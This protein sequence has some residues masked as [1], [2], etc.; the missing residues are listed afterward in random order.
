MP[1]AI[2]WTAKFKRDVK[3]CQKQGKDIQKFKD[4]NEFLYH[5]IP[6]PERYKDHALTGNFRGCRDLHIEPDW[7]LI[8]ERDEDNNVILFIRMGSHAELFNN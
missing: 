6:L 4:V 3:R 7:L 1:Y 5:N 8:Y 2:K